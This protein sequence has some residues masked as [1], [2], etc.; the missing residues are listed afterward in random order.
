MCLSVL[1]SGKSSNNSSAAQ[2]DSTLFH[3]PSECYQQF[4]LLL[5]FVNMSVSSASATDYFPRVGEEYGEIRTPNLWQQRT[6]VAAGWLKQICKFFLSHLSLL[7]MVIIYAIIGALIFVQLEQPNERNLCII[8]GEN[9]NSLA[10]S[11]VDRLW[12]VSSSFTPTS[13]YDEATAALREL[14]NEFKDVVSNHY[15]QST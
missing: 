6:T 8:N 9:Y 2:L 13:D 1:C 3:E 14:I 12:L 11:M 10:A 5:L 7:A 15:F 4:K